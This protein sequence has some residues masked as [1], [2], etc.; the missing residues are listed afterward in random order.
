MNPLAQRF[1]IRCSAIGQIMTNSR[2]KGELSKTAQ[3]YC[4]NWI[5]EQPEF[6]GRKAFFSNKYTEK[7]LIVEDHALDF[8]AERLGYGMLI[9]NEEYFENDFLTGTPDNIQPDHIIDVKSSWS[10]ETFPIFE[11]EP[12][13]PYIWQGLGYMELTGRKSHKVIYCLMNTP[14]HL[15]ERE[16]YSWARRNGYEDIDTEIYDRFR[17]RMTYDGV[18]D[19]KRLKVFEVEYDQYKVNEIQTRVEEC[20][21]FIN[22]VINSL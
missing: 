2:K 21:E 7:G 11:N 3:S 18:D 17:D 10:W 12:E 14:E 8:V 4:L 6:Y 16:A 20:R 1:K 9:K 19:D 22:D 13:S 15:I 5:K